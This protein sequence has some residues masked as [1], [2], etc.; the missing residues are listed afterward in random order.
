MLDK[1]KEA[2]SQSDNT[3]WNKWMKTNQEQVVFEKVN[4]LE[5]GTK[6]I[7][8]YN[9]TGA[10]FIDCQ[11]NHVDFYKCQFERATFEGVIETTSFY[12]ANFRRSTFYNAIIQ[13]VDFT[14]S[15]FNNA[16][17]T[18]CDLKNVVLYCASLVYCDFF[19]GSISDSSVYGANVWNINI[20]ETKQSNLIVEAY[21]EVSEKERYGVVTV[22]DI[23]LAQFIN[24]ILNNNKVANVFN[25][26]SSKIV[27]ILGRF[28]T[29]R[30]A[31]LDL[32]RTEL[33]NRNYSPILFDFEK[34]IQKDLTGTVIALS[35]MS[36]FII[37]DLTDGTSVPW[38]LASII[39]QLRLTPLLPI[40][41]K[42]SKPFSMSSDMRNNM[43]VLKTFEYETISI[44]DDVQKLISNAKSKIEELKK[45]NEEY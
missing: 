23:E 35:Q 7:R 9:F 3:I 13:D 31:I 6:P 12:E 30:K 27:L 44:K 15:I 39:P 45:L 11:F 2:I 4:F 34:P 43:C 26:M 28:T 17:F 32:M 16:V 14:G 38:E 18:N 21:S 33:R 19:K 29:E 20:S 25:T 40:I 5:F 24:L 37:A 8:S 42:G 1:L 41:L 36:G 22:D 10:K